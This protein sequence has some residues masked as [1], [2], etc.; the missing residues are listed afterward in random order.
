MS[1]K[2]HEKQQREQDQQER[3]Q[4]YA[5]IG[6]LVLDTLGSPRDLHRVQVRWLWEN[7]YRVN[8][9]VAADGAS[10]RIAHSFFLEVDRDGRIVAATPAIRKS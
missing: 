7:F 4:R 8:I 10:A 6:K 9:Y 3:Q 5:V 2:Q 1:T